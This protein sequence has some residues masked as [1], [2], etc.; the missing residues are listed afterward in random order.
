MSNHRTTLKWTVGVDNATTYAGRN[1][2]NRSICCRQGCNLHN[3]G[4]PSS[5]SSTCLFV[6]LLRRFGCLINKGFELSWWGARQMLFSSQFHIEITDFFFN[7]IK[8][9][10]RRWCYQKG[11]EKANN[12][13]KINSNIFK[14]ILRVKIIFDFSSEKN[15]RQRKKR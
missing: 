8:F 6:C 7:L 14:F 11:V 2:K 13:V 5:V 12:A 9:M 1:V 15:F 4:Q 10:Q 3:S